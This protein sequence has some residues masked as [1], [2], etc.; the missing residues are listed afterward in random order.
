[1]LLL[2]GADRPGE[3][4]AAVAGVAEDG[5]DVHRAAQ[6]R[7]GRVDLG[8]V[9]VAVL[10]LAAAGLGL[11]LALVAGNERAPAVPEDD[12]AVAEQLVGHQAVAA[13][14]VVLVGGA[15]HAVVE[16][17]ARVVGDQVGDDGLVR[18]LAG[19]LDALHEQ[20]DALPQRRLDLV[21]EAGHDA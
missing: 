13:V 17:R 5:L 15:V 16:A 9:T 12:A 2:G 14:A 7:Q 21:P 20:A 10:T 6:E 11:V 18:R 19:D 1:G 8:G 3:L 4:V